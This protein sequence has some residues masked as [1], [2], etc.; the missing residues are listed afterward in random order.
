MNKEIY[1]D[2]LYYVWCKNFDI[3]GFEYIKT[4]DAFEE[5]LKDTGEHYGDCTRDAR[6]C[7]RCILQR[8]EVEATRLYKYLFLDEYHSEKYKWEK[9][10]RR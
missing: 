2:L 6:P 5:F 1:D 9:N 4:H 3:E 10:E 7:S 8:L